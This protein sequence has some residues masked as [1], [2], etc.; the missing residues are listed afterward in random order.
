[1]KTRVNSSVHQ[2]RSVPNRPTFFHKKR[3]EKSQ[4]EGIDSFFCA[5]IHHFYWRIQK[6]VLYCTHKQTEF[7]KEALFFLKVFNK[8]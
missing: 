5:D 6:K 3:R 8:H 4:F 1:M 7:T 2:P